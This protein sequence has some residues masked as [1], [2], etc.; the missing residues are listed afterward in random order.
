MFFTK[1]SETKRDS[2]KE[3]RRAE[4]SG[5]TLELLSKPLLADVRAFAMAAALLIAVNFKIHPGSLLLN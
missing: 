1:L 5:E 2:A 3:E 4:R